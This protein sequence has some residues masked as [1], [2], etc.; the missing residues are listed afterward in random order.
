MI[1]LDC[2]PGG[3]PGGGGTVLSSH[4]LENPRGSEWPHHTQRVSCGRTAPKKPSE[5]N[6]PFQVFFSTFD[7]Y[8]LGKI[9]RHHWKERLKISTIAKFESNL[10]KANGDIA[11][12]S[13]EILQAFVNHK[14]L[15]DRIREI[16][17]VQ[18]S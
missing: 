10:L 13:C 1:Y 12:R 6:R 18:N 8:K 4:C 7:M 5:I 15:N 2:E 11:P 3:R 17:R 14:L 9:R 16:L